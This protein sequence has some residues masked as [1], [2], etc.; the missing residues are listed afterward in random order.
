MKEL[1]KTKI[2]LVGVFTIAF[3]IA[4]FGFTETASAGKKKFANVIANAECV[5]D[6]G[7]VLVT[8]SLEQKPKAGPGTYEVGNVKFILEQH[9]RA[10]KFETIADSRDVVPVNSSFDEV[11]EGESVDVA[12]LL[13]EDICSALDVDPEAN[14]LR[15]VVEVEVTNSNPKRK[16]GQIHT[17]R[18][19]SFPNPCR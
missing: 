6:N 15:A 18:C 2:A 16:A 1:L 12:S 13:Y 5:I 11:D 7:N 4:V 14:A 8:A 19:I 3:A 17:G 10:N 9:L